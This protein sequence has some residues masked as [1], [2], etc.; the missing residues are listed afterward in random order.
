MAMDDPTARRPVIEGSSWRLCEMPDLGELAGEDPARQNVVDHGII[1]ARD[2]TW[3]LWA[4]IRGTRV[5]RLLFGWTGGDLEAGE[6]WRPLGVVA[7]AQAEFGERVGDEETIGAPFF[8]CFDGTYYCFY[9]STGIHAMTS[10]DGVQYERLIGADGTSMLYRHGGRDVMVL[11]IDGTYYAYSTVSTVAADG[12]ASGFVILRTSEDLRDWSDYTVVCRGGRGGAGPVSAESPFVVF[13]EG[14][15]YLFRA[16]SITFQTYVYRS[17]DPYHFA[18]DDDAKLIATLPIKAPEILR[19]GDRWYITDL[20]DFQ[21]VRIARLSWQ[22]DDE[23]RTP[24]GSAE[25]GGARR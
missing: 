25:P 1:Q 11:R 14:Y 6:P 12:W 16:S 19:H 24:L 18:I 10:A 9:H 2:G 7:R 22:P 15:Y 3:Q 5:G 21:G 17:R 4:C 13:L 23:V 8:A 20:A